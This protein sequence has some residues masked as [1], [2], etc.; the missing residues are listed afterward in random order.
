MYRNGNRIE[1]YVDDEV[2]TDPEMAVELDQDEYFV[3]GDNRENSGDSRE[4]RIGTVKEDEIR[5]KAVFRL[6][7]HMGRI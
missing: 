3:L 7:P 5:A 6:Y 1:D 2:I 4:E